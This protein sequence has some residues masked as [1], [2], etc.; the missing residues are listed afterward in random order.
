MKKY[1]GNHI[2]IVIQ[3]NDPEKAGKIKIFIPHISSTIYNNWVG[4][5]KNKTVKFIGNNINEDLTEVLDDL[6]KITPWADCAAPLVGESSSGRFNN[7]NLTGSVSDSNF[8]DTITSATSALTGEGAAPSN[9]YDE[10]T[11]VTDAFTN[12]SENVNRLIRYHTS[13]S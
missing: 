12:A 4:K 13:I 9:F 11:R 10:T 3:N 6:K 2:G 8:L 7:F 5:G 1:Y